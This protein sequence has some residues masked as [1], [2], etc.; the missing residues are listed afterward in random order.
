MRGRRGLSWTS[1]EKS[2]VQDGRA[3][4]GGRC[5]GLRLRGVWRNSGGKF[6]PVG[7]WRLLEV[8]KPWQARALA[9]AELP[10]SITLKS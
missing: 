1:A 8:I 5:D 4:G 3:G 6:L 9:A 7:A 10:A 2:S